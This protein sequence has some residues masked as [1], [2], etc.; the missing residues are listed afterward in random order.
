MGASIILEEWESSKRSV[1]SDLF[2]TNTISDNFTF[3]LESVEIGFKEWGETI[4]SRD[5]DLL[6]AWELELSSSQSFLSVNNI[7]R[8]A[9]NGQEDLTD[10]DSC[11]LAKSLTESTSHTLL[12][13][14]STSAGEHLVDSNNMPWMNS[15]SHVEV[16]STAVG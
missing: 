1:I 16:L 15:N 3:L 5:E 12:E 2:N 8:L 6:T 10:G 11:G 9:S 4:L 7:F 14:I 13:S